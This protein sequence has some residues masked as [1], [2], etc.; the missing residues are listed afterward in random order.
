MLFVSRANLSMF[1]GSSLNMA[2]TFWHSSDLCDEF[3]KAHDLYITSV[4]NK[5]YVFFFPFAH[6]PNSVFVHSR[7]LFLLGHNK[8]H[9]DALFGIFYILSHIPGVTKP[10]LGC[11]MEKRIY[12]WITV[13]RNG[14]L[15]QCPLCP[16]VESLSSMGR[17]RPGGMEGG[18]MKLRQDLIPWE[19]LAF[20]EAEGG[21]WA[22][23]LPGPGQIWCL[24]L[25]PVEYIVTWPCW[26]KTE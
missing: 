6:A 10:Y 12:T 21:V 1:G 23:P 3:A 16:V 4:Y 25:P 22:H 17:G 7:S 15:L 11:W 8:Q 14:F 2:F 19:S 9:N 5:W 20:L 13:C 18:G 24:F 26:K